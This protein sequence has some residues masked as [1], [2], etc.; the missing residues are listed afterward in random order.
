ML[1]FVVVCV[2][3]ILFC[4]W[5][6]WWV[7]TDWEDNSKAS[8]RLF[9]VFIVAVAAIY[10]APLY[11][12]VESDHYNHPLKVVLERTGNAEVHV[13]GDDV[14]YVNPQGEYCHAVVDLIDQERF[15]YTEGPV[16]FKIEGKK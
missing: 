13:D 9:W 3:M 15:V 12:V 4:T 1:A 8:R 16:C 6:G 14:K 5:M 2:L 7:R 10:T 11:A